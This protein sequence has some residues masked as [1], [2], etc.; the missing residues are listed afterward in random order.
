MTKERRE[1]LEYKSLFTD[2]RY[3]KQA[4]KKLMNEALNSDAS[5]LPEFTDA[6]GNVTPQSEIYNAAYE[7][8]KARLEAKGI[9]RMPMKAEMIIEANIIKAAFDNQTFNTILERTAGKVK[10]EISIG[11]GAY[12]EL[13]DEE[14]TLLLEH[15][16]KQL[17]VGENEDD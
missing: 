13:T 9:T 2:E 4:W 6:K 5:Q 8:V 7:S 15:R 3:A 14:I 17:A 1:E 11:T 12:E 16:Q 10:E